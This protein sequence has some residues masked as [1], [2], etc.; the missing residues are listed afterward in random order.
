[1]GS[2]SLLQGI[3]P[4]QESNPDLLHCRRILYQLSH[5]GTPRILV[6]VFSR[7]IF[8]TQESNWG[9]L[10]C[11]QIL[12]QLSC[13]MLSCF[14]RVQLFAALWTVARQAPLSMGFSVHGIL[15]ARYWSQLPFSTPGELSDPGMEP[16]VLTS[17]S[18]VGMFFTTNATWEAHHT[19]IKIYTVT[20]NYSS[21]M[22]S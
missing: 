17:P 13:L 11:R 14:S 12:Y 5:Q 2:L 16:V 10:L 3:F 20:Q 22:I 15:Q 19:H 21:K 6:W 4:T 18:L 8:P 1:M 9:L 7:Q